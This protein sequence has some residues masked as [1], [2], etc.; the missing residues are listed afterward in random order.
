MVL[1]DVDGSV[2]G[3]NVEALGVVSSDVDVLCDSDV[4]AAAVVVFFVA[5]RADDD[6]D[7]VGGSV[8]GEVNVCC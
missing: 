1:F 2:D 4:D 5:E 8:R 6:D 3:N 7:D